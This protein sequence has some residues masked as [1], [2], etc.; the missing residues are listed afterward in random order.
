MSISRRSL[1]LAA[2]GALS[3]SARPRPAAA[4]PAAATVRRLAAFMR[5]QPS[6]AAIGR[7]YLAH[8][9]E[10]AE[11]SALTRRIVGDVASSEA[12]LM[13]LDDRSLW[14]RLAAR[15]R[16]DFAE[17]R[18]ATVDGWLLSRTEARL[19]ALAAASGHASRG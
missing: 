14:N 15:R 18:L 9:P 3:L 13:R 16:A 4:A 2:A 1:L 6:A 19:C 10:E 8:F 17:G 12:A 7:A 5:P 11:P